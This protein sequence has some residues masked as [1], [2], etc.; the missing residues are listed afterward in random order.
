MV[1]SVCDPEQKELLLV[2]KSGFDSCNP[3]ITI[4]S[5][6]ACSVYNYSNWIDELGLHRVFVITILLMLG[7]L[8]LLLG[9]TFKYVFSILIMALFGGLILLTYLNQTLQFPV[10]C[11]FLNINQT[12]FSIYFNSDYFI[13][14]TLFAFIL[15]CWIESVLFMLSVILG[16]ICGS[17]VYDIVNNLFNADSDACYWIIIVVFVIIFIF[18]K[19][20]LEDYVIIVV[21]SLV[22]SYM[23]V[24]AFSILQ[25][26][27]PDEGYISALYHHKEIQSI[28]R[29]ID[30]NMIVYI[31]AFVA[32]FLVGLIVQTSNYSSEPIEEQEEG[33]DKKEEKEKE[34][35]DN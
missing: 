1:R 16:V 5:S 18:L 14:S 4:K 17:T 32:L 29:I 13:A 3:K 9:V 11:K 15:S 28:S 31:L 2:D 24:R 19:A 10:Y 12:T 25:P 20:K 30:Q 27:F 22:G 8:F 23:I 21:T 6:A 7:S 34:N 33:T 35:E 26:N